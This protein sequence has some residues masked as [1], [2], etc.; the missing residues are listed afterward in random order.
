MDQAGLQSADLLPY[1]Q[2]KSKI[3]EVLNRK[4]PLSLSMIRALHDGLRI[5]AAVLV[6]ESAGPT[7]RPH[8][9]NLR[10]KSHRRSHP[11]AA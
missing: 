2:S 6:Q 1:L 3:S 10:R 4:R 7:P 11:V 9:S 8:S 5:P